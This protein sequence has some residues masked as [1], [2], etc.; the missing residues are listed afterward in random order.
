MSNQLNLRGANV[1]IF[2]ELEKQKGKL[3]PQRR[4]EGICKL[5]PTDHFLNALLALSS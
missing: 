1:G 4:N 3:I 5:N 2:F